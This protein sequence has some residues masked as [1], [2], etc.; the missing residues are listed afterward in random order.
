MLRFG[1]AFTA[2][3]ATACLGLT[4]AA[5][6]AYAS[7]SFATSTQTTVALSPKEWREFPVSEVHT[8]S[9]DTKMFKIQLPSSKH[10]TGLET[11][12]CLL[13][14]GTGLDGKP[15]V[16][17]YT[18]TTLNK[19]L[20]HFD[21]VIKRYPEGNVSSYMHG[22]KPGDKLMVKGP[23]PKLKV[24]PNMKRNIGMIAGGTGITPMYQCIL[25]LLD[26]SDDATNITL[27]FGNRTPSDILLKAELDALAATH[28]RF[29]LVYIVDKPDSSWKG[30][31]GYITANEIQKYMPPPSADN[32][33]FVC[34][35]P[36]LM[37]S[38]SGDKAKDKSQGPLEGALK[39]CGFTEEM[40]Y[41][42]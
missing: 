39:A 31:S 26:A 36:P 9:H 2:Q 20:G 42:F 33:V 3:R 37:K 24:T 41:K 16:R 18:P 30:L 7:Q 32:M 34:G 35:P 12:S 11:A 13:V 8:L 22:L 40:V 38:I 5:T 29:K 17:P 25:E 27:L 1:A 15:T 10:E 19:T 28:P 23:F 6:A 14:Q 4:L 21:L